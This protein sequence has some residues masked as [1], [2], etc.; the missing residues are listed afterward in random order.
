MTIVISSSML[1]VIGVIIVAV[2]LP[3][4]FVWLLGAAA[5]AVLVFIAYGF[6]VPVW[7]SVPVVLA[8]LALAGFIGVPRPQRKAVE[9]PSE[10]EDD[11]YKKLQRYMAEQKLG[12]KGDVR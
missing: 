7:I 5:C 1:F 10:P 8:M 9:Q 11:L 3:E 12:Q 2:A 4:L 6:G